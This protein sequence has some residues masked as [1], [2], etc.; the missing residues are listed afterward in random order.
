MW[1]AQALEKMLPEPATVVVMA[2][3]AAVIMMIV[4]A[5]MPWIATATATMD[6]VTA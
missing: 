2:A 6:A 3:M 4:V 1:L 5:A